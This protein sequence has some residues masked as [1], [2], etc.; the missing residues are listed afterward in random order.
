MSKETLSE[1]KR[2]LKS[3]KLSSYEIKAY[4]TLLR[5]N[6]LSARD[7]SQQSNIPIGRIYEVLTQL[8]D[9]TMI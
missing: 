1:I 6:E 4:L 3:I 9:K 2:L 5:F 8:S 7:L